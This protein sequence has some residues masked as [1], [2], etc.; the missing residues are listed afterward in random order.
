MKHAAVALAMIG[1]ALGGSVTVTNINAGSSELVVDNAGNPVVGGF[2]G[3]GTITNPDAEFGELTGAEV[4]GLFDSFATGATENPAG[5]FL[6]DLDMAFEVTGSANFDSSPLAGGTI[7]LVL[8]NGADLASSSQAGIM[9]LGSF[10]SS[11]PTP[12]NPVIMSNA[13]ASV[14]FGDYTGTA[15]NG[16]GITA[17]ERPAF[18]LAP[19]VPEPSSSLLAAFAGLILLARRKR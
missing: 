8:G 19:L 4:A 5:N 18:S 2:V 9:T 10:P 13:A 15:A 17:G 11:E 14:I 6:L 3:V 1:T 16:S 7:Y 12:P